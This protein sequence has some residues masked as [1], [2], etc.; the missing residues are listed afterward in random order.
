MVEQYLS[1][2]AEV[3]VS[4]LEPKQI[5]WKEARI[6]DKLIVA[7]SIEILQEDHPITVRRLHYL[8]A[9]ALP[10]VYKNTLS[11]YNKLTA[12]ITTARRKGEID[13]EWISDPT[14]AV[15]EVVSWDDIAAF[16]DSACN[17][18]ER[19]YYQTQDVVIEVWVEKD[20]L[21]SVLRSV[22]RKWQMT[23]RSLHGQGS[24]TAA[25]EVAKTVEAS[26]KEFN[27]LYFGDMDPNGE[28]IPISMVERVEDI[29]R[30]NLNSDKQV[31]LNRLGFNYKDF[32]E[33][34]IESIDEK[35]RDKQLA[36]YLERHGEDAKFAEVEAL[37]KDVMVE[38][39]ENAVMFLIDLKKWERQRKIEATDKRKIAKVLQTLQ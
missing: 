34:D 14:R 12:L 17:W 23:L 18:Y 30:N 27:V 6:I 2:L 26:D 36:G 37:P 16:S 38:R 25:F 5:A 31:H 9:Q 22:C 11:Q 29:L 32:N 10:D 35:P 13:Y 4:L 39:V 20:S 21:L 19:N 1:E 28:S 7:K 24:N 33:F 8:L 3:R 15:H